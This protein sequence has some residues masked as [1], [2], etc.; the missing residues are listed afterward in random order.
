[1]LPLEIDKSLKYG[2]PRRDVQNIGLRERTYWEP[3]R[4]ARMLEREASDATAASS[5][6]DKLT[7]SK[8]LAMNNS[9]VLE[10]KKRQELE[11][12]YMEHEE[13][14]GRVFT[15][16][17]SWQDAI[18][19]TKKSLEFSAIAL[20][21][22]NDLTQP[23]WSQSW[24]PFENG[25]NWKMIVKKR[26]MERQAKGARER[27]AKARSKLFAI[28]FDHAN[29]R[30]KMKNAIRVYDETAKRN[31]LLKAKAA[32][33]TKIWK[34]ARDMAD[35]VV[36]RIVSMMTIRVRTTIPISRR[37][38]WLDRVWALSHT[39]EARLQKQCL[40]NWNVLTRET[41][42]VYEPEMPLVEKRQ[43]GRFIVTILHDE[44][45][46]YILLQ[47]W[48]AG[49]G[50]GKNE[51]PVSIPITPDEV[52]E[53]LHE[54]GR[55]DLTKPLVVKAGGFSYFNLKRLKAE[56][57][58]AICGVIMGCLRLDTFRSTLTVGQLNFAR[59]RTKLL[60]SLFT[61][62]W[63]SDM[64]RGRT[65]GK[66]N[67]VF[68]EARKIG[69][70]LVHVG[71]YENWGDMLFECYDAKLGHVYTHYATMAQILYTVRDN[72]AAVA[73][74]LNGI[75][76][77]RYCDAVMK[78]ILDRL[79]F[80]LPGEDGKYW[81]QQLWN[82]TPRLSLNKTIDECYRG[83]L[84]HEQRRVSGRTVVAKIMTS[85]RGDL[86]V[87]I[88]KGRHGTEHSKYNGPPLKIDIDKEALRR[89]VRVDRTLLKPSRRLALYRFLF[90]KLE[91]VHAN[92]EALVG[93]DAWKTA[94]ERERLGK[95]RMNE[96][97]VAHTKWAKLTR[98]PVIREVDQFV[99]DPNASAAIP[100]AYILYMKKDVEEDDQFEIVYEGSWDSSNDRHFT[101]RICVTDENEFALSIREENKFEMQGRWEHQ[102]R[103][104][105]S[106]EDEVSRAAANVAKVIDDQAAV[107]YL[108]K[109]REGRALE[110][111][112]AG[113][114][115][116]RRTLNLKMKFV[117]DVKAKKAK[118][119]KEMLVNA[120]GAARGML[121]RLKIDGNGELEVSGCT[122]AIVQQ[123]AF[124]HSS[125]GKVLKYSREG[126]QLSEG[127]LPRGVA[128]NRQ[129]L[130]VSER[131]K[132]RWRG[133]MKMGKRRFMGVGV[134]VRQS[135]AKVQFKWKVGSQ[136][137]RVGPS[138]RGLVVRE[139]V[140]KPRVITMGGKAMTVWAE[141][142]KWA[143][144]AEKVEIAYLAYEHDHS[145][146]LGV[147]LRGRN[148]FANAL[149]KCVKRDA[150]SDAAG[151]TVETLKEEARKLVEDVSD[152][153]CLKTAIK[154]NRISADVELAK[155]RDGQHKRDERALLR[156]VILRMLN[157]ASSVAFSH[158][159]GIVRG[160]KQQNTA[161]NVVL[162]GVAVEDKVKLLN[163]GMK[164]WT[165][166]IRTTVGVREGEELGKV[167]AGKAVYF[168]NKVSIISAGLCAMDAFCAIP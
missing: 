13:M 45:N 10:E 38:I 78:V 118:S 103:S 55:D 81:R 138:K 50:N 72:H 124:S 106:V 166:E 149:I 89:I 4:E 35:E 98:A 3:I 120:A 147:A 21:K 104:L 65:S 157:K 82:E 30:T 88:E 161:V 112:L 168:F 167:S 79:D 154:R 146:C 127:K 101:A 37:L 153:A 140:V 95:E 131:R 122:G 53:I 26:N 91:L 6:L 41:R 139:V 73:S 33:A 76:I 119:I 59:I 25:N 116:E 126:I 16:F 5:R 155:F 162:I 14:S 105:M 20:K 60:S 164:N 56:R 115:M 43:R 86:R 99:Y 110:N 44:L 102:E 69:S 8:N 42:L 156:R 22:E 100:N 92:D 165:D 1:M 85:S 31:E 28:Y 68:Q 47:A 32:Y 17:H 77:N 90:D 46:G 51:T 24:D 57:Q 150:E 142:R 107:H 61:T 132:R 67:K 23:D 129:F 54:Q 148:G 130:D 141:L 152:L 29:C 121:S 114:R 39:P 11:I 71:V 160:E 111:A 62:L 135:R 128:D 87:C 19:E 36:H 34:I 52:I 75:R 96:A 40:K 113:M 18:R 2:N 94:L 97:L 70:R 163:V 137:R 109:M 49:G 159:V 108:H 117:D 134:V 66:G 27:A 63:W 7:N 80:T 64:L 151:L 83:P 136:T 143:K 93:Q 15:D 123:K 144:D 9:K 145:K 125:V 74:Y 158:W 12:A 58:A 84:F 48:C 133:D